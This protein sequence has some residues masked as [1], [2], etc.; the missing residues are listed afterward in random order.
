MT[1]AAVIS[2]GNITATT[3]VPTTTIASVPNTPITAVPT[4]DPTTAISDVLTTLHTTATSA[5]PTN[6]HT[7]ADPTTADTTAT[8]SVPTTH[9]TANTLTTT[10]TTTTATTMATA[11]IP[12]TRSTTTTLSTNTT[13]TLSSTMTTATTLPTVLNV[14]MSVRLNMEYKQELNDNTSSAYS[15]LTS[16]ILPVLIRQYQ[17]ITG[18]VDVLVKQ[19]RNGS[20]ITDFVVRT[21]QIIANELNA[22]NLTL[23]EAMQSV[24][25]VI[26]SV[27]A[28]YNSPTPISIPNLTYTGNSMTLTCGIFSGNINIGHISGSVWKFNGQQINTGGRI[29]IATGDVSNLTVNNII[30]ADVG[31]YECTLRSSGMDFLQS[32]VVTADQIKQAPILQLPSQVNIQCMQGQ[33]ILQPLQCCVQQPYTVQWFKDTTNLNSTSTNHVQK[34]CVMYNYQLLSCNETHEEKIS[35]TCRVDNLQGYE[36]TTTVTTFSDAVTCND[37]QYGTGRAGDISVS[38]CDEGQEGSKTAVCQSTGQWKLMSDTCIMIIIKDFL[39][40]S[41]GLV[42]EEVSSFVVNLSQAVHQHQAEILN[43]SATLSAIVDILNTIANVPIPIN[44]TVMENVLNTVDVIIGDSARDS[45]VFLNRNNT[46]NTSSELLGSLE[47]LS[48]QLVGE[49]TIGTQRILLNRTTFNSYFAAD[50]NS[51][52]MINIPQNKATNTFITTIKFSSLNNVLPTRNSTTSN[53]TVTDGV[54]NADVVLVKINAIIQNVTLSY[55]KLNNSL[56]LKSRCVFWNF[57]LFHNLGAW[58]D[59]GCTLV[60]DINNTVTCNCNHLTSFSILMSDNLSSI[61]PTQGE[62]LDIITYVGVGISMASLVICLII[63]GCVWKAVTTNISALI[64]HVSIVNTTLSLLIADICFIIGASIA[65]NPAENPGEDYNVPVGPCSTATFFMHFFYLAL[66]FWMLV[67]GLL[68]FYRVI[69]FFSYMSRSK[70]LAISF[71]LGYGCP[72]IIAVITVAVTAPG[73]GYISKDYACWLNWTETKA[74][75]A[76]VIPALSIV[77]INILILI[78]VLFKSLRNRVRD[79]IQSNEKH[80]LVVIARCVII[81]TP[82]FGLTWSL[83]VGTMVSPTN[84]AIHIAFAFFNSLQGF[85][86]LVFGTLSDSKVCSILTGSNESERSTSFKHSSLRGING[87]RGRASVYHVSKATKLNSSHKQDSYISI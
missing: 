55:V 20:V 26:G 6:S 70:T 58:D 46:S 45:W 2:T 65:K 16:R 81:L 43:S 33:T 7:T 50:L 68:L 25:P 23:P 61:P 10:I 56:P 54:I 86:V 59:K 87:F 13:S 1:I 66:F 67:S 48:N 82:L 69:T 24:A 17:G 42:G 37:T 52:I 53:G 29:N 18:F 28:F 41:K 5:V 15:N 14:E 85:C 3:T 35:F 49:F 84:R 57:T 75:L 32:G 34:Y 60:T 8:T 73:H 30:P 78:M 76:L 79:A 40:Y 11:I 4:T 64:H 44:V 77:F 9:A 62:T 27:S 12:T 22:A 31:L 47:T 80:M 63:E 19:F 21:T 71:S 83:G 74:L 39:I 72:L 51:S 36:M 38:W